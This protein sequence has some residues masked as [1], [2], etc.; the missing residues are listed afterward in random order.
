VSVSP[1]AS[2]DDLIRAEV[3]D[4]LR[5]RCVF[6]QGWQ[7]GRGMFGGLVTGAMCRLLESLHPGRPLRSLTAELCGPVQPGAVIL[8]I[9]RLREGNAVTTTAIKVTQEA[10]GGGEPPTEVLA[11]GV[12]VMGKARAP[13]EDQVALGQPPAAPWKT[14][15][16]FPL[17]PPM[18]PEFSQYFEFRP[19]GP[20]PFS[21]AEVGRA[22][23]WIRPKNPGTVRDAAYL[24][25]CADAYWP[26]L[27]AVQRAPRPMATIA[28]TFQPFV[29]FDGLDVN[30]PVFHRANL[31]AVAEGYCVEFR[32]LWA[33]DGR[34]LA[35]NQQTFAIIK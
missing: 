32:E 28:F 27:F 14:A 25:A 3:L 18:G 23:G 4:P 11:H 31:A 15:G 19:T 20:M 10:V 21:G 24:A 9:D 33:E 29:N 16:V 30:A 12:A 22:E 13:G 2:L 17:G 5:A 1:Q 6:P 35:L 34:L 8:S 7:Q 26:A